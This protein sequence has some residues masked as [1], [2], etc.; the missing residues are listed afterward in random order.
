MCTEF[1]YGSRSDSHLGW[2]DDIC[3][4]FTRKLE[5]A[6]IVSLDMLEFQGCVFLKKF[7]PIT[8]GPGPGPGPAGLTRG[9]GP[10]PAQ[11][12]PIVAPYY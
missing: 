7:L 1:R 4:F 6:H 5:N 3:I 11:R 8:Q 12:S 2:R 10:G 9:P